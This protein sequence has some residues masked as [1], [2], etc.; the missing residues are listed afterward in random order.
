MGKFEDELVNNTIDTHGP[1]NQLEFGVCRIVENEIML[2]KMGE[3]SATYAA[4]HL[5]FV[6]SLPSQFGPVSSSFHIG[7]RCQETCLLWVHG[8]HMALGPLCS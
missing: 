6:I 4:S 7:T 1:A 8:S 2:V 5:E 3:L